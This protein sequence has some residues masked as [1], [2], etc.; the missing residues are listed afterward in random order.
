MGEIL[1]DGE[2]KGVVTRGSYWSGA[3]GAVV[4]EGSGVRVIDLDRE[5]SEIAGCGL[6]AAV[7]V[8]GEDLAYVLYTSGST[9]R[10]KG[11]VIGHRSLVNYISWAS[12]YYVGGE[13]AVFGLLTPVSFDLTV[14]SL[15][16]PLVTGNKLVLYGEGEEPG[17]LLGRLSGSGEVTVL[18]VT[19]S[20][21]R[22][23]LEGVGVEGG[24]G[25]VSGVRKWI[26]GGE[27][28]GLELVRKLRA[29]LGGEI[30]VYNEYGPTEATVG[31]MIYRCGE[32]MEGKTVPI[33]R[34]IWNTEIYLLDGR[35]RRVP[36]GV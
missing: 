25:G 16:T 5:G 17:A 19:P 7:E 26:V 13:P 33:G 21:L 23:L 14:T 12:S 8:G 31:C 36:V 22:L 30:E 20:H 9:G 35:G 34:G 29:E 28:L 11:V 15:Y 10:P 24:I 6:M 4:L 2:L 32:G 18:K 27:E 1:G 3:E